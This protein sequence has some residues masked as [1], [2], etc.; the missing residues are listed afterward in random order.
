MLVYR[1]LTSIEITNMY[2]GSQENDA[3]L[4]A[5]NTH[6][7]QEGK[8][9]IHFF[10]YSQFAEYYLKR[11]NA[12]E[13][14]GHC[15][16]M[17]YMIANIPIS[18]LNKYFGYGFYD[19]EDENFKMLTIPIPEYAIDTSDFNEDYIIEVNNK[20]YDN[21]KTSSIQYYT[22][23]ELVRNI[24]IGKYHSS[25]SKTARYLL[26]NNLDELM[27]RELMYNDIKIYAKAIKNV[28]R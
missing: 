24:T 21:Y 23:L 3:F 4:K 8:S 10:P 12:Q 11:F 19:Y 26:Q 28:K 15:R 9:Y 6:Q 16:C 5:K 20:I 22:Y 7:Y 13:E 18:I 27:E 17:G 25:C 2:T 1:C 14:L